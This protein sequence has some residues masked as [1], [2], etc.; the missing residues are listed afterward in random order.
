[1]PIKSCE[2]H[3]KIVLPVAHVRYWRSSR[4]RCIDQDRMSWYQTISII[5]TWTD[6]FAI[7]SLDRCFAQCIRACRQNRKGT[8]IDRSFVAVLRFDSSVPARLYIET[9][10]CGHERIGYTVR[11][12]ITML[13]ILIQLYLYIEITYTYVW[14]I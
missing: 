13:L 8:T 4:I 10:N 11:V 1:M 2:K 5:T 12:G 14:R 9:D 6:R 7:V 3:K